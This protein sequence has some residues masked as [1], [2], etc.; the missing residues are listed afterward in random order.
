MKALKSSLAQQ[1]LADPKGKVQLRSYL[2]NKSD[3]AFA[4][5]NSP[6]ATVQVRKDGK[7]LSVRPS[8][9]AKAV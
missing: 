6:V 2:E 4:G 7:L 9:V 3:R 8:I 5:K 1:I